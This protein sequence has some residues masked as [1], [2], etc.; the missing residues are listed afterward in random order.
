MMTGKTSRWV[1]IALWIIA[2]ILLTFTLPAV[3]DR[4]TNNAADLPEDSASVVADELIKKEFP[5]SSGLPAL[6]TWHRE[7]GLTEADLAEIQYLSKELTDNPLSQQSFLPPLHEIPLPALQGSVSEDGTTFV[8]PLFFKEKTET[9]ILEK[10]LESINETV[11]ECIGSDPFKVPTDS[12]E[13]SLRVTGPV[14]ISVDATGLFSGADFKLL[15]ATVILVLVVLLLIYR[16]PLLAIIPLIG[17]GFAYI[18]TSPILGFMADHGWITVDSQAISIMTVLLFGAGTDY[19]LFLISHYRSELRNHESKRKAMIAAFKDSSGAIAMSGLTIVI[20][21]LTLLVAKYGAY[22]RFAVPFSLSILIMML[23]ALTLVPALLSVFGRASFFPI[24]PRTPEM[25]EARAK[26]KGKEV[27]KHKE[28]GRIGNWIGT[29]VTTKP[30]TVILTCLIIFSVLAGYSSQIKYS[31]D[32]LSSFPEDMNSSEGYSVISDSY[33]PGELAPATVVVDT[34]GEDIDLASAL[35]GMNIVE[36]VAD[37]VTS[38]SNKDLQSYEVTFNINPY[39]I[40]A[41][42]SIPEIRTM[43]EKELKA[44]NISS[45]DEKVWIGGQT[46]TQ[47][48]KR[49]T[50]KA[51]EFMIIPI[52]IVL[53]SLLLLAYLRSVTAMVYLMGTVI[54]SFFAAMGLGWIILHYFMGVDAIE[55]TIP[56]YSFVFL[57]ALGEDYNIF[58]VS[59]IW[60]KKKTM[61]IKQAI[62][63][64]V[65]ETSGVITS[66]GIILA[67]TFSVLATLPIQVLVQ[68]GL[69]TALGV[70]MDTFIVRPFL[71]PAIT[72]LLGRHAFW[73][74]KVT[75]QKENEHAN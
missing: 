59:S 39:N 70:L 62:R 9:A 74:S 53:I 7:G 65:A 60:R 72:S 54:L 31:Y 18:V 13:L 1:V 16:S 5:K 38:K 42:D 29:I 28:S 66:A 36:N 6:L 15:L 67:A 58:M 12:G 46:A 55:G 47:F 3:N 25:E 50:V 44:A 22:H 11:S 21:L 35:K 20:S 4:T 8:H 75:N 61:P 2:A 48:D 45:V 24:V 23:A 63:K 51:D 49:D 52:I 14:G 33:S 27:K 32:I 64:G 69:I 37:P 26:K 73:P 56:L 71:V 41:I 34:D 10:N 30:W 40:E 19:C 43:A 17:V 68:F 57:V